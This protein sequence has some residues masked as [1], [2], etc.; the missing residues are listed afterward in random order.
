MLAQTTLRV[1][2]VSETHVGRDVVADAR[3]TD[4][5]TGCDVTSVECGCR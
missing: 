1:T 4:A 5:V 2:S 3:L